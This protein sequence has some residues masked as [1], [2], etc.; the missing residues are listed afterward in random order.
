MIIAQVIGDL[1]IGGAERLFVNLANSL[2]AET[3]VILVGQGA[4]KRDL[5]KSL[6]SRIKVYESPV[7]KRLLVT[8]LM[9]L[10]RLFKE[11]RC[12]VVHTH[13]FWANLYGSVAAALAGVPAII[14]SEHGRNEWKRPWHR[15]LESQVIG[16]IVGRR[17]C[18]SKDILDRRRDVDGIPASKLEISPNGTS[19]PEL[20][21]DGDPRQ[22]V[23]GSVGRLVKEKDFPTLVE[24]MSG[25][26][27]AGYEWR[28]EIVGDGPARGEI[29]DAIRTNNAEDYVSLIGVDQDVGRWLRRWSI[30]A[31]SSIQE[32]QPIAL[33]EA[34]A[35]GL[36]CV[37]TAVGG[38][39]DT[40]ADGLEGIIVPPGDAQALSEAL[41]KLI[42][43]KEFRDDCGIAARQR[44][45][46]DFS[47]GA[48]ASRCLEIYQME[49]AEQGN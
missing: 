4:I 23:I 6:D 30:F 16:R 26:V 3:V 19:I 38:V 37:A 13:M 5:Q 47:I 15:W 24:A 36:P 2:E 48:L 25:L 49:L 32:G 27:K 29:E 42:K 9:R 12:D 33:L 34:M 8:D 1:R 20:D 7:R 28:L 11:L 45:V 18:V 31:S 40:L 39:P 17:L 22:T 41:E 43:N 35:H 10:A 14:T 21:L 46:R 44:V